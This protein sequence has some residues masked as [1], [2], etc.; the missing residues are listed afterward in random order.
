MHSHF[1]PCGFA[2][3]IFIELPL[4]ILICFL[5]KQIGNGGPHPQLNLSVI[6]SSSCI[7]FSKGV[8]YARWATVYNLKQMAA[9][10]QYLQENNLLVYEDAQRRFENGQKIPLCRLPR[11]TKG[12]AGGRGGQGQH[13]PSSPPCRAREKQGNGA[14]AE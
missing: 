3:P 4:S 1:R 10:L 5:L 6:S 14:I 11:R 13:R 8:A 12:Y 9:A 7:R 2:S